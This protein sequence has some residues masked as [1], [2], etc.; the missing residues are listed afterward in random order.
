[1]ISGGVVRRSNTS[2]NKRTPGSVQ[3]QRSSSRNFT[4]LSTRGATAQM[5]DTTMFQKE[6]SKFKRH[7]NE[8]SL[9]DQRININM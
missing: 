4:R 1:M 8:M 7:V 5:I 3:H 6:W 2:Q 9:F